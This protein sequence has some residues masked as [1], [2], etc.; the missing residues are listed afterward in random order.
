MRSVK[1]N[2]IS[3]HTVG[4]HGY[5][6]DFAIRVLADLGYDAVELGAEVLPWAAPLVTPDMPSLERVRL[7][8]LLQQEHL[9]VSSVAAHRSFLAADAEKR[10]RDLQYMM[11][12]IELASDLEVGIAHVISGSVP[13]GVSERLAWEWLTDGLFRCIERGESLGVK[14]A[15]EP[16]ACML[17]HD[18][19][20]LMKVLDEVGD[21][22]AVN[23]D[24]SHLVVHGDDPASAVVNLSGRIVHVHLKDA[25]GTPERYEFP[26]L[27]TGAVDFGGVVSALARAGYQ[28]YVS[29]EYEAD[30]F[31]YPRDPVQ[32]ARESKQFV[33]ALLK[34]LS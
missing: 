30:A 24:P 31:G 9:A 26:P 14:I 4:F 2:G 1:N 32:V 18:T 7:R 3:F 34:R 6:L 28:G 23:F 13:P 15:I 20:T 17:V 27:G 5:S 22:L 29:V 33:E 12:C 8:K 10:R 19:K 21:A 16:V 25:R 11:G